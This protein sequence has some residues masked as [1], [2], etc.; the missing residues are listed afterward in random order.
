MPRILAPVPKIVNLKMGNP[1][2]QHRVAECSRFSKKA[3]VKFNPPAGDNQKGPLL[4]NQKG[5]FI[6]MMMERGQYPIPGAVLIRTLDIS[7]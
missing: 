5:P 2:N 1:H 7:N 3:T 6:I 4:E